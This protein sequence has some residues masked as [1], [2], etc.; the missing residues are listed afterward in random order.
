M[1]KIDIVSAVKYSLNYQMVV[2]AIMYCN[3]QYINVIV[4]VLRCLNS[5]N[6]YTLT[7]PAVRTLSLF[8]TL[9]MVRARDETQIF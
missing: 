7:Y 8:Q 2:H 3:K 1:F 5:T 9:N 6:K 4:T